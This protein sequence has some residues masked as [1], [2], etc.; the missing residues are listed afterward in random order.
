MTIYHFLTFTSEED[1]QTALD[2]IN[3]NCGFPNTCGTDYWD[4]VRQAYQQELWFIANPSENGYP[5]PP[6][7]S[8]TYEQMMAGVVNYTLANSNSSWWPPDED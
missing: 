1:A 5:Q 7:G 4:I 3:T 8:F 6:C 2:Q